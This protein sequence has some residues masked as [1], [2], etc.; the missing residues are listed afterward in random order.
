MCGICGY[1]TKQYKP[2]LDQMTDIMA[3]RGPDDRG[4]YLKSFDKLNNVRAIA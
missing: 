4:I 2:N 3:H 1:I